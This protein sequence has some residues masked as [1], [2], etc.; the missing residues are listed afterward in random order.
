MP[1]AQ[2]D[3]DWTVDSAATPHSMNAA[4]NRPRAI[5]RDGAGSDNVTPLF[6]YFGLGR[7][8]TFTP[9]GQQQIKRGLRTLSFPVAA[10]CPPNGLPILALR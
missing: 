8:E 4:A 2:A 10:A 5:R 1:S 3:A 9:W 6:R 7:A